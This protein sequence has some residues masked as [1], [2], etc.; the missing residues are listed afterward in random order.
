MEH[1]VVSALKYRPKAFE[2]VI[3]QEAI[4]RTLDNA[5]RSNQLAQ[6]LLFCGPRGVGKTTCARIVARQVNAFEQN[7]TNPSN[8]YSFN[9][10]ELDAASNNSVDDIRALTDQVRIPPQ[11]GSYKVY[12]IDEVHMLS[13]AAFNA[14]LKTLEEPPKHA[15][16]ILATTEKHKILP[17]ILSRCQIYDFKRISI[18]DTVSQLQQI[19]NDQGITAEE[20]A[21]FHIAKKSDG[22]LRD[23]LSLFDRLV[24]FSQGTLSMKVLSEQLNVL[25]QETF[26]TVTAHIRA[27]NTSAL[28][29]H[30][31][32]LLQKGYDGLH[33]LLGLS[34]HFRDLIVAKS[35]DTE[36]LLNAASIFKARYIQEAS[37]LD[38]T[39]LLEAIDLVS[40]HSLSYKSSDNQRLVVE[41]CLL[42]LASLEEGLSKKKSLT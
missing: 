24:S 19:A 18:A 30:F 32:E 5:I 2:E 39:F 3:G 8:D 10:F 42:Q 7:E 6:A 26:F 21:L 27:S 25:D 20:Q 36:A 16:F 4:T 14:F 28:L 29:L 34:S 15:I 31:D 12:I 11:I 37:A 35:S 33:F 40:A 22:A 23:A 13:T 17:T 1:F 41:L 9:I 38:K